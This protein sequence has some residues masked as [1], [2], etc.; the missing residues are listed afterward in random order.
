MEILENYKNSYGQIE[1]HISEI[2]KI[3]KAINPEKEFELSK[4][5]YDLSV[6][7][8]YLVICYKELLNALKNC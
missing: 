2:Q 5:M 3:A 6:G 8:I 1:I 4:I 7:N